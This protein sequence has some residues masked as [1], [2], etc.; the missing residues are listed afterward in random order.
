MAQ[1]GILWTPSPKRIEH[2]LLMRFMAFVADR[3]GNRYVDYPTLYGWSITEPEQFWSL[4]WDFCGVIGDKGETFLVD[5]DDIEHAR[6][7]PEARLNFAEN[8]LRRGDET[9]AMLFRAED[10]LE[11]SLSFRQ[12]QQQVSRA[13]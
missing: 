5:G 3:T 6:W 12:L 13:P 10:K 8:L 9:P 11:Y 7:F 1:D 2:S 4:I